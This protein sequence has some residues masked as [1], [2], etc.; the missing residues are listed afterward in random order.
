MQPLHISAD[1]VF[2]KANE[3]TSEDNLQTG[4]LLLLN[5][6]YLSYR[7]PDVEVTALLAEFTFTNLSKSKHVVHKVVEHLR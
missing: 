1:E 3:L 5:E 7:N 6:H 4:C 2:L